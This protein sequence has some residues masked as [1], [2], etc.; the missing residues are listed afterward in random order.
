MDEKDDDCQHKIEI[1]KK[2]S[3]GNSK[4]I[5]YLKLIKYLIGLLY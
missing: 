1:Y 3:D 5:N 4:T 2:E